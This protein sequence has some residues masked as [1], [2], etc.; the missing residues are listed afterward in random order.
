MTA[1]LLLSDAAKEALK[2]GL[3]DMDYL[4]SK[5]AQTVDMGED[6]DNKDGDEEEEDDAPL[7]HTDSAYE[8]G[9]RDNVSKVKSSVSSEEKK[10]SKVKKTAKQEV[11]VLSEVIFYP[12]TLRAAH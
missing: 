7:Q 8:S 6:D 12:Q 10:Q 2:S 11:T 1:I 3:S 4:R 5:V 9:D